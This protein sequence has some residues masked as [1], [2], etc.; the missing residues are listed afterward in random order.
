MA[1]IDFRWIRGETLAG[2]SKPG[3]FDELDDDLAFL[4]ARGIRL[5]VTLTEDP[6]DLEEAP[7]E[8][9]ILHFPIEDM[10]VP[11]PRDT[12]ALC[13]RILVSIEKD[14]PVVVHCKAGL[15][16][17]GTIL[18]CCLVTDGAEPE[19]AIRE[20]RRVNPSYIQTRSQERFV[21][22][23]RDYLRQEGFLEGDDLPPEGPELPPLRLSPR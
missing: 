1:K 21:T 5:L 19:R 9:E 7:E 3:L 2:A 23:Y 22:H 12:F 20:I 14:R 17:T 4:A 6:L 8:M 11:A 13:V 15:G 16:R 10:S 18:A